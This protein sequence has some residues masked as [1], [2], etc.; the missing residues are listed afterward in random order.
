[1][2]K[3][4]IDGKRYDTET[5]EQVASWSNGLSYSDFNHCEED[6]YRTKRGNWFTCGSGG[7]RSSY[8]RPAGQDSWTGSSNII[9]ALSPAEAREW[10]ENHNETDALERFFPEQIE[11]A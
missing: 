8:C 3:K 9:R 1:M 2:T 7:P 4:I 10:L 5:A 6:L 11:D